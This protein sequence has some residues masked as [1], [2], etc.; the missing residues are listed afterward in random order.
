VAGTV[1]G[2][3]VA[4]VVASGSLDAAATE[5]VGGGFVDSEGV[6]VAS[7]SGAGL[8]A[9]LSSLRLTT[10]ATAPAATAASASSHTQCAACSVL[11][12]NQLALGGAASQ[13]T[14]GGGVL[15]VRCGG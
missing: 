12:R 2:S 1:G 14:G 5:S 11:R 13:I 6:S 7:I 15:G 10:T 9:P 4:S 3:S 8:T